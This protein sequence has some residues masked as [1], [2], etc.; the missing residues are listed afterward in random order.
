MNNE[1]VIKYETELDL[2]DTKNQQILKDLLRVS[3][4]GVYVT[5]TKVNGDG[6]T[7]RCT[8]NPDIIGTPN[9]T[10]GEGR[11][12]Y[13]TA[14]SVWDLDAKGWRSFRWDSVTAISYI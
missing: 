13:P 2:T 9:S 1:I 8:R 11:P 12:E 3:K 14:C 10:E 4:D 5:F 6:R 7:M